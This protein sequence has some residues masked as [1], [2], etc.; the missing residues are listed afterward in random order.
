MNSIMQMMYLRTEPFTMQFNVKSNVA[1][2]YFSNHISESKI[3]YNAFRGYCKDG[4]VVTMAEKGP[5]YTYVAM[6]T[7][8]GL[9]T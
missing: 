6:S 3:L 9:R 4:R 7:D 5:A 8:L 1:F 2:M